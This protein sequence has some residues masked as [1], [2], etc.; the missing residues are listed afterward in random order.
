MRAR[1]PPAVLPDDSVVIASASSSVRCRRTSRPLPR[2]SRRRFRCAGAGSN[3]GSNAFQMVAVPG[4]AE[5]IRPVQRH[6]SPRWVQEGSNRSGHVCAGRSHRGTGGIRRCQLPVPREAPAETVRDPSVGLRTGSNPGVTDVNLGSLHA[7]HYRTATCGL[8]HLV[9]AT[10][11]QDEDR[12]RGPSRTPLVLSYRHAVGTPR[13]PGSLDHR[14][15]RPVRHHYRMSD[16]DVRLRRGGGRRRRPTQR[17]ACCRQ[18]RPC[19]YAESG[20]DQPEAGRVAANAPSGSDEARRQ[21][22]GP[23]SGDGRSCRSLRRADLSRGRRTCVP[24]P[25]AR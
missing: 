21:S 7:P 9:E 14:C 16:C 3:G 25:A 1:S 19:T 4:R 2:R 18:R 17:T 23:P 22:D 13:E 10:S 5:R 20:R 6:P 15:R 12:A 8:F 11:A 24:G